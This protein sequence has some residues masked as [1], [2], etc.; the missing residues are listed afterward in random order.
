M[1]E[2][3]VLFGFWFAVMTLSACGFLVAILCCLSGAVAMSE[4][5]STWYQFALSVI[6]TITLGGLMRFSSQ[7]VFAS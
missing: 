5:R 4:D 1:I 3:S 6:A 2:S 7:I